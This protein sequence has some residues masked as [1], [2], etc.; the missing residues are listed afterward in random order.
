MIKIIPYNLQVLT[1]QILLFETVVVKWGG[2][3]G[4]ESFERGWG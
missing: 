2:E 3:G 1:C 4:L